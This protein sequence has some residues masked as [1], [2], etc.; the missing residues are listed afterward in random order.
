MINQNMEFRMNEGG[1]SLDGKLTYCCEFDIPHRPVS[2]VTS[3]AHVLMLMTSGRGLVYWKNNQEQPLPVDSRNA[4]LYFLPANCWRFVDICSRRPAHIIALHFEL[5]CEDGTDFSDYYTL[6]P[7]LF[8]ARKAA[9]NRLMHEIV[10]RYRSHD[11]GETLEC[12]RYFRILLGCF[13]ET[14]KL[15]EASLRRPEPMHCQ[16]AVAY[17]RSHYNQSI[18]IN[19]LAERCRVSRPYFFA[20]FRQE[21]GMTA[22]QYLCRLRIERARKLLLF[23]TKSV[24]EIGE[25]VGWSDP[26]HFSRIFARETGCSPSKFRHMEII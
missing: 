25:E 14:L 10:K 24:A 8:M 4:C 5:K 17:L 19:K 13:C 16:P 22:Q 11:F 1:Y 7:D 21:N 2:W 9:F 15:K 6:A 20:L 18:D 12:E 3:S 26:F 23:S